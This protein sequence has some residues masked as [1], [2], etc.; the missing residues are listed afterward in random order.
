MTTWQII[1]ILIGLMGIGL[2]RQRYVLHR[3]DLRLNLACEFLNNFIEW[4]NGQA[5][6]HT[7]YNWMLSKSE[8]VQ[9]MLGTT[10]RVSLRRPFE[11]GYHLNFP[12]ILNGIPEI[13]RELREDD[14][15]NDT[16][17]F[18]VQTINDCLR[19][20]IGRTEEE[21][22]RERGRSFNPIVL[23]CGGVAWLM[24]LPLLILSETKIITANRRTV[25]RR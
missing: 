5:R 2:I 4:C 1:F 6:D 19:R 20:F 12:I 7:L 10:G 18:Y 14:P 16:F 11:N 8:N 23:F 3:K 24:E 15:N 22:S 25:S 9:D 17:C 21:L 13:Q